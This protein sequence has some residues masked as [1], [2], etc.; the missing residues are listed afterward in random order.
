[1]RA[2]LFVF[3]IYVNNF[4]MIVPL[5]FLAGITILCYML[6]INRLF[7]KPLLKNN[8][9]VNKNFGQNLLNG[10]FVL[11]NKHFTLAFFKNFYLNVISKEFNFKI[12]MVML[13]DIIKFI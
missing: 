7:K 8:T 6:A 13:P 5:I 3:Y 11:Q 9:R 4:I 10:L 2:F 1:M 12:N